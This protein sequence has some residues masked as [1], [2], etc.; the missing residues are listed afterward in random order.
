MHD[1]TKPSASTIRRWPECVRKIRIPAAISNN[2]DGR[3]PLARRKP[4]RAPGR[5][6]ERLPA[7]GP[8]SPEGS[9]DASQPLTSPADRMTQ[10]PGHDHPTFRGDHS[11]FPDDYSTFP[12]DHSRFPD[13][14]SRF[15]DDHSRFPG[16]HS[17]FP[18]DHS[19]FPDDHSTF[20]DDHSRFPGDHS[21]FPGDHSTFPG[22]YS[23]FPDDY[24][25]FPDDYSRFQG[26][27]STSAPDAGTGCTALR[28]LLTGICRSPPIGMQAFFL[29]KESGSATHQRKGRTL[30]TNLVSRC[31]RWRGGVQGPLSAV[32]CRDG[33]GSKSIELDPLKM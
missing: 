33:F 5:H 16:D 3:T 17:R 6:T 10:D 23:T 32:K 18:D 9:P 14:H 29:D 11:T 13:D 12:D 20:P 26:D 22:D 27:H 8:P 15:P 2:T 21:T 1:I 4:S 25:T 28:P 31:Q 30:R 19:T 7:R 24:S